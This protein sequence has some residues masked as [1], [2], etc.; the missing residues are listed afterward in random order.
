MTGFLS[1]L[2]GKKFFQPKQIDTSLDN[3]DA[4]THANIM[5]T[6]PH[7]GRHNSLAAKFA[8][9]ETN[10]RGGGKYATNEGN[11]WYLEKQLRRYNCTQCSITN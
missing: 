6:S 9:A 8:Y 5:Q 3:Y 7:R 4:I 11:M 10:E 2:R 1:F